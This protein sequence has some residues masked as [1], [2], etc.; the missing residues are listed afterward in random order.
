MGMKPGTQRRILGS[1]H[2]EWAGAGGFDRIEVAHD[3]FD[4]AGF[5]C[6][7]RRLWCSLGSFLILRRKGV[8]LI[9]FCREVVARNQV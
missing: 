2:L 9:I 8:G 4:S 6:W 5:R 3:H 1:E 7:D